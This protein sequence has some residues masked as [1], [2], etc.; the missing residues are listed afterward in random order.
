MLDLFLEIVLMVIGIGMLLFG[1][2]LL[3]GGEEW[4]K[5]KGEELE[6]GDVVKAKNG[7]IY[8]VL[9]DKSE[10]LFVMDGIYYTY[11]DKKEIKWI[12]R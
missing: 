11:V 10:K 12:R 6:E 1:I 5:Y 8:K 4:E 2:K 9:E 7:K 3:K